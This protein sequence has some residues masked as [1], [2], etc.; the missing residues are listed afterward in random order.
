MGKVEANWRGKSSHAV[1]TMTIRKPEWTRTI[2]MEYWNQGT[3]RSL[4]KILAPP[5][6]KGIVY[7]RIN[8]ELWNYLPSIER[9]IR[10]PPSMMM[11]SWMGSN[12]T[13]DDLVRESNLERDYSQELLGE[14]KIAG[15]D[16]Y[17]IQLIPKPNA[18]VVWSKIIAWIAK[19]TFVPLQEEFYDE[20]GSL[21]NTL[22]FE[23]I[24]KIDS[25]YFPR[26]WTMKATGKNEMT[27]MEI[28]KIEVD[29]PLP[30]ELFSL[31][32]LK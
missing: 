30:P 15:Y 1:M 23:N 27:I 5:K 19:D 3:T 2:S 31:K 18:P 14:E 21:V 22:V 12:F 20:R 4:I 25:R 32:S 16:S 11:Q 10:I 8:K 6:D 13:N 17:R 24:K 9:T 29:I 7:L 26:K 28:S